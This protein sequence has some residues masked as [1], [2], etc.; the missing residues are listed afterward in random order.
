MSE[1]LKREA[2]RVKEE[3]AKRKASSTAGQWL[4]VEEG[5]LTVKVD[6]EKEPSLKQSRFGP[7]HVFETVD[8][9]GKQVGMTR[10]LYEEFIK[11]VEGH[12]G[13]VKVNIVRT[14]TG[15]TDTKYKVKVVS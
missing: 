10:A 8:P 14:G 12:K 3:E 7:Q 6:L 13:I 4:K 15:R 11:A 5:V 2:G 9:E 1:W